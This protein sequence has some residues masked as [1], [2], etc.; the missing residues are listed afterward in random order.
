MGRH[1]ACKLQC[2]VMKED[3]P[4]PKA[5][6]INQQRVQSDDATEGGIHS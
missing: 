6:Q 3:W 2:T 5:Q 1:K 4:E